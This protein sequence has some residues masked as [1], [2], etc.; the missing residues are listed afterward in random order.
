MSRPLRIW[1][2]AIRAGS[3]ADVFVERLAE[4]LLKA[5]HQPQIHWFPHWYELVPE[6]MRAYVPTKEIDLIH[7]NSWGANAFIGAGAPLVI[8][9]LHLVHD[10]AYA[11]YRSN[12]QALYHRLH[13]RRREEKAIR[14]SEAVTAISDYVASTVRSVFGR[15]D[16]RAIPNW[17]DL[18]R[19]RPPEVAPMEN[20]KPF[21]LLMVGNQTRRK[22]ADLFEEFVGGLGPSFELSCTGGL[23]EGQS[24]IGLPTVRF[25][26]CITEEELIREY[27]QC[28]AVVSLSRYEGFGYTA[29]EGM[30]CAKPFIGFETSGLSDV[31]V[32]GQT[33]ILVPI[34]NVNGMLNACR[35][36]AVDKAMYERMSRSARTRAMQSFKESDAIE[37]YLSIYSDL[38][39]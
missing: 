21:R 25:L 7:S 23:R 36:L 28:D 20:K 22:G 34:N 16:V 30:A 8:T 27:Q 3:G 4:G 6:L 32:N 37:T 14:A 24:R 5:G 33:G 19:Y 17:V 10:P 39:S 12:A 35:A 1:L 26:G 15:M 11:S 2:P 9:V 29:L 18:D 31:V 13:V 38:L